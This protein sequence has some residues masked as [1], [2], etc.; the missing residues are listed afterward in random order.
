M[1]GNLPYLKFIKERLPKRFILFL[2]VGVVN[3]GFG[4]GVFALLIY[5]KVHY[6]LAALISTFL[7]ILFN[8]KTT[9]I[10]V[11]RNSNNRL[12]FRFFLTYGITYLLGLLFL[13]IT[14]YFK[15]SNYIAGAIWLLP[16]AVISY[17]LMKSIVFRF[18]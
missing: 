17:F 18:K 10:I 4:Y 15:I 6:S 16:G 9:G 7:G 2:I 1:S 3:T 8:F 12:I 14:N 5:F 13:Y 11:F